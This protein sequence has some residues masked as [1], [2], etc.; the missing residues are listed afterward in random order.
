MSDRA[1]SQH[2]VDVF[3]VAVREAED[4]YDPALLEARTRPVGR[5]LSVGDQAAVSVPVRLDP[6]RLSALDSLA[7]RNRETRSAV[8]RRAIDRELAAA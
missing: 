1:F 2:A 5:P 6:D 8:I 4:G 3:E 7:L